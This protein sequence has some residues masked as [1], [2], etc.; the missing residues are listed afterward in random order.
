VAKG[1]VQT[2]TANG[3]A[4]ESIT[5]VGQ[6]G[7]CAA[8]VQAYLRA[9]SERL[10]QM[11]A[12]AT[13]EEEA[14]DPALKD[15]EAQKKA[16]E[17]KKKQEDTRKAAEQSEKWSKHLADIQTKNLTAEK[18]LAALCEQGVSESIQ[19]FESV[20]PLGRVMRATVLASGTFI[21]IKKENA[22][23]AVGRWFSNL[24]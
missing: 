13:T 19:N 20:I 17:Q 11:H 9:Q 7:Q 8:T 5:N 12:G 4:P 16:E 22:K 18:K 23:D 15:S 21:C 10:K 1:V 6:Y 14:K 24:F 2:I 3:Q